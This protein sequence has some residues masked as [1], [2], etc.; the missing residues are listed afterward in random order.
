MKNTVN[1]ILDFCENELFWYETNNYTP[2]DDGRIDILERVIEFIQYRI[3]E[4]KCKKT[5]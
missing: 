5:K 2:A 3:K 1:E 4:D